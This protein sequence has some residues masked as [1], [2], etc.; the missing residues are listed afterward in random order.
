MAMDSIN[1][2]RN[3]T[4]DDR[5]TLARELAEHIA[6][7]LTQSL[8]TH[9]EAS[10]VVSGGSTPKPLFEHL[11]QQDLDWSRVT[12]TLADERWVD[13]DHEDS[14]ARLVAQHLLQNRATGARFVPLVNDAGSPEEGLAACEERLHAVPHPFDVV[15][16][17]MG[18]DGH[19]ASLFPGTP[20]LAEG[21]DLENPATCLAVHPLDAPHPRMS[22]TLAALLDSRRLILHITG[23][24]KWEVY[25]RALGEGPED[26]LPIRGALRHAPTGVDVWWAP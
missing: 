24:G 4:F 7:E 9:G 15:V 25:Q 12:V 11:S 14:N 3:H 16:L 22:L 10:L 21:L 5:E 23:E 26:E 18:S 20:T 2:P 6:G 19:T 13:A 1:S 8:D 17:G